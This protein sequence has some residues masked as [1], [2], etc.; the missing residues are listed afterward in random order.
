MLL[1]YGFRLLRVEDEPESSG[2]VRLGEVFSMSSVQVR[3][4]NPPECQAL[5]RTLGDTPETVIAVHQLRHGL[6]EAYVEA[7][8]GHHHIVV[9]RPSRPSDE[10]MAFGPDVESLARVLSILPDWTCVSAE[11]GT[12]RRLGPIL[13]ADLGRPVR[14]LMDVYHTADRPVVAGSHPSVRYVTGADIDLLTAAPLDIRGACLGFGTFERLLEAGIVAGAVVGGELVAVASTWAVSEKYADL[15]VVTA[16]PWQSG[17][18]STACAGL[19]VV[20]IRRSGR[21]P[22]WSTGEDN[23]AS[24]RVAHKLGFEEVGRRTYVILLGMGHD[25]R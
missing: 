21:V 2:E 3:R 5:I 15:S 6:C 17:G 13:E 20:D 4:L 24:L 9:L 19:V 18:L 10:L 14:H 12:A 16:G 8:A 23:M 7:G 1:R 11:D 25:P 22:V